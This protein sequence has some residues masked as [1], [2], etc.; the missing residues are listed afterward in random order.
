[1]ETF[2]PQS[3]GVA[4]STASEER[5]DMDGPTAE[6]RLAE[7]YRLKLPMTYRIWSGHAAQ[8]GRGETCDISSHA[9]RFTPDRPIVPQSRIELAI[10]WPAVSVSPL[11]LAVVGRVV[12]STPRGVVVRIRRYAVHRVAML[13]R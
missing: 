7:R 2:L 9:V 4:A 13:G 12:D 5:L 1:M 6:R 8:V 3:P 11:C 10:D